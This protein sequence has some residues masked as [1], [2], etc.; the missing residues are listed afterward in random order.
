MTDIDLV[1]LWVDGNDPQWIAKRN[2]CIGKP[3]VD[4]TNCQGRYAD[5]DELK[6]SLR[7]VDK[8]APWIRKIFIVTDNQV[9]QWLDTSN[10]KIRIVDHTEILPPECRPCFNS[11]V[12]EHHLHLIPGLS[13]HF[14]YAN[15]DMFFNKPVSPETFFAKDLFPIIRLNYRFLRK[16]VLWFKVRV[17]KKPL[18]TYKLT[19]HHSA[20]LVEKRF[21]TYYP[22][23]THHNIDSYLK[24]NYYLT[25]QLFK[26]EI[27][28]TLMNHMRSNNDIQRNIY[29]FVALATNCGHLRYV[30]QH[31]S[32]RL[33]IDN[34]KLYDKFL[35][36]NPLLFCMND[37]QYSNDTDRKRAKLFLS[38]YFPHKSQFEK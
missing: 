4:S 22:G 37:S 6:Y 11:N 21:G 24:S 33:H 20:K 36:Y 18:S 2:A 16:Y 30:S 1:Y 8:Y 28:A 7:S 26:D 35:R 14:L 19:I 32:F 9:P 25:R 31:T 38:T 13:E 34:H 15:D 29:S 3:T 17:L 12:I 5:N 10:P 27:D 23:R